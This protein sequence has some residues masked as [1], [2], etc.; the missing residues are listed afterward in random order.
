M[1]AKYLR[2]AVSQGNLLQNMPFLTFDYSWINSHLLR[3]FALP[4]KQSFW[5][6]VLN[7][8]IHTQLN[9]SILKT[10][11][12]GSIWWGLNSASNLLL[13]LSPLRRGRKRVTWLRGGV[14]IGNSHEEFFFLINLFIYLFLAV[15]GLRFCA[16]AFSSCGKWGPLF[17]AVRG[18]LTIAASLVAEHRLQTH[19]LSSCG[20]RA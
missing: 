5:L 2:R 19:R 17:F 11:T 4:N 16:R 6:K 20:A 9:T 15:L 8:V 7:R 18:P 10:T 13:K 12:C 3:G 1:A 14:I